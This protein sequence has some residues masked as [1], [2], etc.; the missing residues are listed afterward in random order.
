MMNT[1]KIKNSQKLFY[2]VVLLL[3]FY[4]IGKNIYRF[5]GFSSNNDS[6][7][8]SD[9]GKNT[10][11][12]IEMSIILKNKMREL[13]Q[14]SCNVSANEVSVNGGWCRKISGG[15][16]PQHVTDEKLVSYLSNF[17]KGKFPIHKQMY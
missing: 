12:L 6:G 2:L 11:N 4:I 15:N 5:P 8:V 7:L 14:L 13:G 3:I 16:S 10:K 1:L 9:L 17:L